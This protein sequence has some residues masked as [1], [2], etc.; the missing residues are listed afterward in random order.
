MNQKHLTALATITLLA[1]SG[2]AAGAA[3]AD[4][5]LPLSLS[6]TTSQPTM[7]SMQSVVFPSTGMRK[8]PVRQKAS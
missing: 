7:Q 8:Q 2:V 6:T 3:Q 1:I 5:H 4:T